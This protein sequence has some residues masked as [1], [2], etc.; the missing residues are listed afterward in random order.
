MNEDLLASKYVFVDFDGTLCEYRYFGHVSGKTV[1]PDGRSLGGQCL[2]ELLFDTYDEV[3][4]LKTMQE[5][6]KKL[7]PDKIYVLGAI[8]TSN[9]INTKVKWLRKHYPYIKEE[10]MIFVADLD[11]KIDV[12]KEYKKKLNINFEDMA[13]VDDKIT[14]IRHAEEQGIPSYHITSFVN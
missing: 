5:I 10:N 11:I 12:L 4:P 6:L 8:V 9:E 2:K 7:D 13:F 3:R 14:T 1:D